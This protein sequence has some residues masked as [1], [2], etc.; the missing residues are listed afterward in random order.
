[1]MMLNKK[2]KEPVPTKDVEVMEQAMMPSQMITKSVTSPMPIKSMIAAAAAAV[3][4][5]VTTRSKKPKQTQLTHVL[6]SSSEEDAEYDEEDDDALERRERQ[7]TRQ[8]AAQAQ[9]LKKDKQA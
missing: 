7:K 4:P 2:P 3:Q 5:N 9:A 1:M 8:Y 6:E